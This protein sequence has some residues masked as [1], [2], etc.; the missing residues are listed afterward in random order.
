MPKGIYERKCK[1]S[2]IGKKFGK[3]EIIEQSKNKF[4]SRGFRYNCRCDCGNICKDIRG[5]ELKRGRTKSCGCDYPSW[6]H[7]IGLNE[8]EYDEHVKRDLINRKKIVNDCWEW[9]GNI[10]DK[11]YGTRCYGQFKKKKTIL[12]HRLSYKLWK[13]E[14]IK[15]MEIMHIC[16]NPLCFN[17]DHLLQGTHYENMQHANQRKRWNPLIGSQCKFSKLSEK[18]IKE[19]REMRSKKNTLKQISK[20]FNVTDANI[21]DICQ[22]KTWRHVE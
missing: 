16:D 17:P 20:K 10:N 19:I 13:G 18:D 3:L 11:G 14:L 6:F 5:S 2:I 15:G 8:K 9:T 12:V 1:I 4:K 22:K 7:A 21:S